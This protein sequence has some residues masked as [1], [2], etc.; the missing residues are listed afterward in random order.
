VAFS[1]VTRIGISSLDA[2][3][4]VYDERVDDSGTGRSGPL[5]KERLDLDAIP[6]IPSPE[7]LRSAADQCPDFL[8]QDLTMML[9]ISKMAYVTTPS[10][11]TTNQR[12]Q[13]ARVKY[14]FCSSVSQKR[15]PTPPTEHRRRLRELRHRTQRS[16]IAGTHR[17]SD[18]GTTPVSLQRLRR[19]NC[20]W[21]AR[22]LWVEG[23]ATAMVLR[24]RPSP[25]AAVGEPVGGKGRGVVPNLKVALGVEEST[26]RRRANE[27]DSLV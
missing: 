11:P 1:F 25:S 2:G 19:R 20:V 8:L 26:R 16:E 7:A 4:S 27:E 9:L 22:V 23:E 21:T 15:S 18:I 17:V 12:R 13:D 10:M 24:P 14:L 3:D 5:I 6:I